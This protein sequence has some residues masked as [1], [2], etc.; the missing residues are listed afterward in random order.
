MINY[1]VP[2]PLI[3]IVTAI[4]S[5]TLRTPLFLKCNFLVTFCRWGKLRWS[6]LPWVTRWLMQN[7]DLNQ[8]VWKQPILLTAS[9][10][11]ELRCCYM[12]KS[13]AEEDVEERNDCNERR[14]SVK[15]DSRERWTDV[16]CKWYMNK[17][18]V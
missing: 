3:S 1:Y 11:S 9:T 10:E 4:N 7:W 15:V 5:L 16:W 6:Y 17:W 12:K 18:Y 13:K 8:I 14:M 2:G